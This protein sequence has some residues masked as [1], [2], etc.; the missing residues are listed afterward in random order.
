MGEAK[1]K[2]ATHQRLAD[3]LGE[4]R[5]DGYEA[6]LESVI[7][8]QEPGNID[9]ADR[10]EFLRLFS[11]ALV[12]ALRNRDDSATR[13]PE[14]SLQLMD[15]AAVTLGGTLAAQ[16]LSDLRERAPIDAY[17]EMVNFLLMRI[18]AGM[19]G[20]LQAYVAQ[21]GAR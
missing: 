4:T 5:G 14:R 6:F 16:A 21:A 2:R 10:A 9:H 3:L 20:V 17:T 1:A 11:V 19:G 13:T 8:A 15:N 7:V 18:A 12:E